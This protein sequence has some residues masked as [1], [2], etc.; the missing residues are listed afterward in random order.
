MMVW[1]SLRMRRWDD[2]TTAT[3]LFLEE[4]YRSTDEL[5]RGWAL[6]EFAIHACEWWRSRVEGDKL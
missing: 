4:G 5:L 6:W 1:E 3:Q 2:M